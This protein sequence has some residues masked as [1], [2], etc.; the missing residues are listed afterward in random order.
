MIIG[1]RTFFKSNIIIKRGDKLLYIVNISFEDKNNI[2]TKA[3]EELTLQER[4]LI[5]EK[6]FSTYY[7]KP[8]KINYVK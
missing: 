6:A 1:H 2:Q 8:V 3:T 4:K 5:L 7:K